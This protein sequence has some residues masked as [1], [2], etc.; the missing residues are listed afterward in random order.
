MSRLFIILLLLTSCSSSKGISWD[1]TKDGNIR[2]IGS[3]P[4]ETRIGDATY[5]F[6]LTVFSGQSSKNYCLIISSL[7]KIQNDAVVLFKLGNE[8]V[9][10]LAA[11]NANVSQVDWPT[12]LPIIGGPSPSGLLTT[13]RTDYYT[14]I[15]LLEKDILSK[16]E[17]HGIYKFRIEYG[18]SYKQQSW[19]IDR[20]GKYIKK[21]H[22]LIES[23]LDKKPV[24][25]I[26]D[27]F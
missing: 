4:F 17:E 16:I 26:E 10:K 13:K 25:S 3:K 19:L 11:D 2:H 18:D 14:S 21:S 12:L 5:T 15:F 9:I 23:R 27:G 20:L 6:S 22:G 1:K 8:E 7:W 24:N